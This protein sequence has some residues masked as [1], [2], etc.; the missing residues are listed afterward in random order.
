MGYW[1]ENKEEWVARYETV[2]EQIEA[3]RD[4]ALAACEDFDAVRDAVDAALER[5]GL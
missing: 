5:S 1:R 3:A 2:R 4:S